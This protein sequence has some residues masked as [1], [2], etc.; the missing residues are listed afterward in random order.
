[1]FCEPGRPSNGNYWHSLARNNHAPDDQQPCAVVS[2]TVFQLRT[3]HHRLHGSYPTGDDSSDDTS[4]SLDEEDAANSATA[5]GD[6]GEVQGQEGRCPPQDVFGND[7][8]VQ[9]SRGEPRRLSWT[10]D[11]PDAD[12]DRFLPC[13][14]ANHAID[15]RGHGESF[16]SVL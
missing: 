2:A 14:F 5:E 8:N 1:M 9:R 12:L 3:Q 7:D 6:S 4:D 13:N 16:G 10:H 11:H 15:T